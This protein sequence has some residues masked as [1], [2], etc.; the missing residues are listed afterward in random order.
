MMLKNRRKEFIN[1]LFDSLFIHCNFAFRAD[2]FI[3]HPGFEKN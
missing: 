3:V 2:L 1:C